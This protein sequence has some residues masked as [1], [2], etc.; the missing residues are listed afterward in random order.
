MKKEDYR[1]LMH[2]SLYEEINDDEL[3]KLNIY[4][5]K[6]PE[7]KKEMEELRQLKEFIKKNTPAEI[8]DDLLNDARSQLRAALRKERN[9]A[10]IVDQITDFIGEF[11]RPKFVIGAVSTL[12]LG[13][14]VGYCSFSPSLN[15]FDMPLLPV[16]NT[17]QVQSSSSIANIRFIDNDASDGDVEFEFDAVTPMHIKGNIDDP[18]IQKLL[19]HAL[20]NESNAGVRLSSVHAIRSQTENA[21]TIDPSVKSALITSLKSD[22]NPG[23]RREALR[24]LQQYGWD[25]DIRDAYLHVIAKDE[26]SGLRVA[27]INAL[28]M[29]RMEGATLDEKSISTLKKH[30]EKEQNNYIRNRAA[31]LVKEIYQ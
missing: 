27:A 26:N 15:E 14:L 28:E 20:L 16:A 6:H 31:Q 3:S 11:L 1:K 5:K 12:S 9:R 17:N 23:V 8:T 4:L 18:Q 21:K 7:V 29:A 22:V 19:T 24:V 13:I 2:L 25:K 10:S 30:L